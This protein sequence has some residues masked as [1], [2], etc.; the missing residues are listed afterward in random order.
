MNNIA[1]VLAG[2]QGKRMKSDKPKVLCNVLE[3]PMLEWVLAA[4]E[5]AGLEKVCVVKG[6]RGDLIDEY[7]ANRDSKADIQAVLQ[8][9]QLGTGHAVM[10]AEPLMEKYSDGNV[11]ILNGDAPFIDAETINPTLPWTACNR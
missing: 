4:C 9:E 1:I 5:S 6:F 11:L 10:Q 8:E 2:G 7:L 3:E